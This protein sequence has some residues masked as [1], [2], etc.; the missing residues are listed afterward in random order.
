MPQ[1]LALSTYYGDEVE[2]DYG[3]HD[4]SF[5]DKVHIF[6]RMKTAGDHENHMNPVVVIYNPYPKNIHRINNNSE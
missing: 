3:Q 4:L 2:F 5:V 1:R 6:H